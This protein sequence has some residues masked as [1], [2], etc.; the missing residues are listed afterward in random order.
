MFLHS[1]IANIPLHSSDIFRFHLQTD[2]Y[3]RMILYSLRFAGINQNHMRDRYCHL[4]KLH[5][6][7]DSQ[8]S[9]KQCCYSTDHHHIV[10]GMSLCF[11]IL[12]IDYLLHKRYSWLVNSHSQHKI[13]HIGVY[14]H[15]FRHIWHSRQGTISI[16]THL[17]LGMSHLVDTTIGLCKG[18]YQQPKVRKLY[19][20]MLVSDWQ[21]YRTVS[22]I[23]YKCLLSHNQ[24][25]SLDTDCML[26]MY[27][28]H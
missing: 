27:L 23:H 26:G 17:H 22:C 8:H 7:L 4:S 20:T 1:C 10:T 14:I 3:R 16:V 15:R 2:H 6:S 9:L 5:S 12:P 19:L 25:N 13:H 24:G 11:L 28:S 18:I 21:P